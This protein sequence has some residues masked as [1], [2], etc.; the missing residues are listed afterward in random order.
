MTACLCSLGIAVWPVSLSIVFACFLLFSI[1]IS[2]RLNVQWVY[3]ALFYFYAFSI[4]AYSGQV[5]WLSN[6]TDMYM[7]LV[8][9]KFSD[10]VAGMSQ[11][12]F[13]C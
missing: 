5:L 4:D 9:N 13:L 7:D 12:I 2:D 1:L 3:D 6:F 10:V 8:T 11:L